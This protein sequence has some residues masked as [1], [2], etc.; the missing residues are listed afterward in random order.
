MGEPR[1]D[2][3]LDLVRAST[4][5]L[6]RKGVAS[7]RLDAELLIGAAVGLDRLQ[8]YVQF[9]RPASAEERAAAR[10]LVRRRGTREPVA[11]ILG[12]KEFRSRA[13]ELRPGVLVPRPD[14]ELLAER[15]L[16]AVAEAAGDPPLVVDLGCGSGVLAVTIAL[17]TPARALAVDLAP[18]AIA[19]T[20]ANSRRHGVEDR[21]GVVRGDWLAALPERFAGGVDVIVS[22]PPYV[23]EG[24][25][26]TLAPEIRRFE[27]RGAVCSA[28]DPLAFHRRTAEGLARWLRPGGRVLVEVGRG[29]AGDVER[30]FRDA[31]VTALQ[32]HAD[33]AGIERVVE[34]VWG[35]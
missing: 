11:L 8:L 31:G 25:Y 27:P 13:F 35:A 14:T 5:F 24:E 1:A 20:R 16:E 29:Q 3:V 15:A 6:Q 23:S 12:V 22:N 21:V 34:G 9:D 19:V 18:E 30:L 7:P 4:E 10:E 28:P 17:E 26:A 33:L 32:R 2:T